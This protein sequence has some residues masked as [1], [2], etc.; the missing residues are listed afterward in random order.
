MKGQGEPQLYL[1]GHVDTVSAWDIGEFGPVEQD[2]IIRGLGSAD[3]KGGCAAMLEAW[4]AIAETLAPPERPSV[5][6]LLVVREEENGDGSVSL[7]QVVTLRF[8]TRR[9]K[10]SPGPSSKFTPK[11]TPSCNFF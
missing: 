10:K 7:S 8:M 11:F 3:M 2:G 9:R 1:A 5:G 6:L 4:L